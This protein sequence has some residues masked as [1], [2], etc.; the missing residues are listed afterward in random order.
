MIEW[1]EVDEKVRT[2]YKGG[3]PVCVI[4]N[5]GAVAVTENGHRISTGTVQYYI[6]NDAWDVIIFEGTWSF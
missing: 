1:Q 3:E 6:K 2:Y 4:H 5:P